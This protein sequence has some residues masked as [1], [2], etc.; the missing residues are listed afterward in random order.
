[1]IE[2]ELADGTILEF[3]DG[4]DQGVIDRTVKK[5]VLGA[6]QVAP[7]TP[8]APKPQVISREDAIKAA[9]R[10]RVASEEK[11][12]D[13]KL[14]T[15]FI[16]GVGD[17]L[18]A[19]KAS[20]ANT[21]G[22]GPRVQA[23][24]SALKDGVSYDD[25][26]TYWREVNKAE[27]SQSLTGDITGLVLGGGGAAGA[28]K[29]AIKGIATV[30]PK[31][32]NVLQSAVTLREG[33][34]LKNAGKII[35]TGAAA[36]AAQ[37][38]GEG[39]D[40]SEGATYGAV[41]GAVGGYLGS[42]LEGAVERGVQMVTKMMPFVKGKTSAEA[43]Q[44]ITEKLKQD[45]NTADKVGEIIDEARARGVPLAIGDTGENIR[46]LTS[47]MARKPG[48]NRTIV[49]K[50]VDDRQIAQ[51][52]RIQD[53]IERDLGPVGYVRQM[54]VDLKK[55]SQERA[56]PLF[57][58]AWNAPVDWTKDEGVLLNRILNT[59]AG[60]KALQNART[61]AGNEMEDAGA[62]GFA[63]NDAGDVV[64]DSVPTFKTLHYVKR[65]LDD[66]VESYPKNA[67]TGRPELDEN[68]VAVDKLRRTLVGDLKE[69]NPAY[70]V[71]ME[72]YAGD[73]AMNDALLLG[74][75][76][77]NKNANDILFETKDMTP[78]ELE[79]YKLGIRSALVDFLDGK[80]DGANQVRALIGSPKK[81][82]ALAKIFGGDEGLANFIDTLKA[83]A[84]TFGTYKRAMTGSPTAINE[85]DDK[86]VETAVDALQAAAQMGNGNVTGM[87]Q[88]LL[89]ARGREEKVSE[90]TRTELAK[91]LT[92]QDPD[93]IRQILRQVKDE[94]V[95][96]FRHLQRGTRYGASA[97]MGAARDNAPPTIDVGTGEIVPTEEPPGPQSMDVSPEFD[98]LASRIEQVESGGRQ[99]AI[100][101]DGAV[102]VMQVM[103]GTAPEAA[104]LAGVP[105]DEAR[106]RTD[107]E[108]NRQLGRAYLAEMLNRFGGD[109]ELAVAAYN[110]GPKAVQDALAAGSNWKS[111]LP[112]E[113]Q[114]YLVKV[115]G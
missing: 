20:A 13:S 47:S 89:R 107:P 10:E 63:V 99:D 11:Q 64:L 77:V 52:E 38:A 82:K 57:D 27:R 111:A 104:A 98:A 65:G 51:S 53:A 44:I 39:T 71:A 49:M 70:R 3:P 95:R 46:G 87:I 25:A 30:A 80:P 86:S 17:W 28:G 72:T 78:A 59:P 79:Q 7:T 110:A 88:T 102:G 67:I 21:F 112:A 34:K 60:K 26:L 75:K 5:H 14:G 101:E 4:T 55:A 33:E 100:S 19:T 2:A 8:S 1:M 83:E 48:E 37:A 105:F 42:K 54:S 22:I 15:G 84:E 114:D 62:L 91:I 61:I 31:V 41:G 18:D 12:R 85:A 6:A 81:R 45:K 106:Y 113:T 69:R 32:G 66:V 73:A 40:V 50:A 36:G 16:G 96:A 43:L 76:A 109:V 35:S 68:G 108:Y 29:L 92:E 58:E 103:P 23:G 94:E 56:K 9:A 93:T 115:L 74:S 97:G 90:L 24:I